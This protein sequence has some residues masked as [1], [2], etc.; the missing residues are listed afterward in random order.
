VAAMTESARRR[1]RGRTRPECTKLRESVAGLAAAGS[2][3]SGS[4]RLE[5]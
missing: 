4:C 3:S 5:L 2:F 1:S